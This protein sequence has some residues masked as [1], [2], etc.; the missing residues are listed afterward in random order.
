MR[1]PQGA[2]LDLLPDDDS[3]AQSLSRQLA[4]LAAIHRINRAATASLNLEEMLQ[5]VVT[6]VAE[7]AGTDTCAVY[8][9]SPEED[10]LTLRATVGLNQSAVGETR[11]RLG[12]GITGQAARTRQLIATSDAPAH[13]DPFPS[14]FR[15]VTEHSAIVC[16]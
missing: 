5:T 14:G 6:A 13:P 12:M 15:T 9:Y 16:G 4:R 11:M 8:L 10:I 1:E 7:A 3:E 2:A